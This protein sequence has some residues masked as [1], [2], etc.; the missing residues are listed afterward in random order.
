M[1]QRV[2][3]RGV[4]AEE[5]RFHFGFV[6]PRSTN[7]WESMVEGRS[8][9][10]CSSDGSSSGSAGFGGDAAAGA[11]ASLDAAAVSGNVQI[12]TVFTDG[13]RELLR[14]ICRIFYID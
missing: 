14:F 1:T 11:E 12:E 8:G 9:G 5:H 10:G 2:L 4:L 3:L 13:S 7:T 6:M